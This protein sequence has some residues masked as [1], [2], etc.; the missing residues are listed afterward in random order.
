[1]AAGD[2]ALLRLKGRPLIAHVIA[3]LAPQ[4]GTLAISVAKGGAAHA[5]GLPLLQDAAA[6]R[7]GP[8]AGVLSA[9]I[10]AGGKGAR[11][12]A[13]VPVDSPFLPSD[14]VQRLGRGAVPHLARAGGR[15]HPAFGLW[16]T[17]LA[18]DLQE[19]LASGAKPRMADF[20][21]QAGALW[22]DFP[23]PSAFENLNT[24]ADLARAEARP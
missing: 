24:P 22:V 4:V 16:P 14:L 8:L 2:K 17:A 7:L 6:L 13:V 15:N 20:A 18:A 10:W 23:D 12:V 3:R 5:H 9:L 21:L 19:F 11:H 1:M